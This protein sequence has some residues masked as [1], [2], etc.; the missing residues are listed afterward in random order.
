MPSAAPP[1]ALFF[2]VSHAAK[3]AGDGILG[4]L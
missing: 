4:S 1:Y 2:L 3:P